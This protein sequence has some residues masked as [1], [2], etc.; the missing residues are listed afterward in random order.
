MELPDPDDFSKNHAFD[1]SVMRTDSRFGFLPSFC[2]EVAN[3]VL[4][5]LFLGNNEMLHRVLDKGADA[6]GITDKGY[7]F[8][9]PLLLNAILNIS[10]WKK[11]KANIILLMKYP[12][13]VNMISLC[14][15]NVFHFYVLETIL[16]PQYMFKL[17]FWTQFPMV[18]VNSPLILYTGRIN[19][20]LHVYHPVEWIQKVI[21]RNGKEQW[22]EQKIL[23]LLFGRGASCLYGGSGFLP[24]DPLDWEDEF[25]EKR[26]LYQWDVKSKDKL[27]CRIKI[28][29]SLN[30]R[31][32]QTLQEVLYQETGI[33]PTFTLN[34]NP[35]ETIPA[36]HCLD[37]HSKI[38]GKTFSFHASFLESIFKKH[39]YPFTGEPMSPENIEE[40]LKQTQEK[41]FPREEFPISQVIEEFPQ[42]LNRDAIFPN[43]RFD[44]ALQKLAEW[45]SSF[46]PYTRAYTLKKRDDMTFRFLFK[47]MNKGD[48]HFQ[49]FQKV[50]EG[51]SWKEQFYWACHDSLSHTF[52]F[53]NRLEELIGLLE[54]YDLFEG[55]F[56][57]KFPFARMFIESEISE[58]PLITLYQEEY[59]VSFLQLFYSL[60]HLSFE[61]QTGN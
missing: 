59:D 51:I 11:E 53:S 45:I 55:P 1:L 22:L 35:I 58:H 17:E 33:S 15:L 39:S 14:G 28:R 60:K 23:C 43:D 61:L 5:A 10:D 21:E 42:S 3:P 2:F 50:Y 54:I 32:Q 30:P 52:I 16:F 41:W 37:F 36:N 49:A 29:E 8:F 27:R 40:Y 9:S 46:F 19:R 24:L 13:D 25:L 48:F 6:N 26:L 47:E 38:S 31:L 56:H 18:D 57:L 4:F 20:S 44:F 34:M 12:I 7:P